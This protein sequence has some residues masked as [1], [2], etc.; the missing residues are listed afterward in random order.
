[1]V[2][3]LPIFSNIDLA[4]KDHAAYLDLVAELEQ[5]GFVQKR[6]SDGVLVVVREHKVT[7]ARSKYLNP[8]ARILDYVGAIRPRIVQALYNL[9]RIVNY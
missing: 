7:D 8:L 9:T 6:S 2:F 4:T 5:Q 1:V 3:L